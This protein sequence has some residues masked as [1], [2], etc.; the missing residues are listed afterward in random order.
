[1]Q[2]YSFFLKLSNQQPQKIRTYW[3]VSLTWNTK[4]AQIK[5]EQN[6]QT[7]IFWIK[8]TKSIYLLFAFLHVKEQGNVILNT[9]SRWPWYL[10][11]LVYSLSFFPFD[12]IGWPIACEDN[13]AL[14]KPEMLTKSIIYQHMLW[15]VHLRVWKVKCILQLR[16]INQDH[17]TLFMVAQLF[18]FFLLKTIDLSSITIY[19]LLYF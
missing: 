14:G 7:V 17:D 19:T 13:T 4:Y 15:L 18:I 16:S 1:M 9:A 2:W 8:A 12:G 5:K 6:K 10:F 3:R 11:S